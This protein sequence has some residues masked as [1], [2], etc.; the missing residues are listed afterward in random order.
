MIVTFTPNPALDR[1]LIVP[2]FRYGDVTRVR[3]RHDAAGGKGRGGCAMHG[4][5]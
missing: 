5:H 1:T 3:E 2:G 4:S